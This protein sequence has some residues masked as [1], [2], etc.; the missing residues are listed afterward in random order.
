MSS[1]PASI[2]SGS[3]KE[4]TLDSGYRAENESGQF[5]ACDA[6]VVIPNL[7]AEFKRT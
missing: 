4:A 3:Q 1:R 2:D 5:N 6:A 7:V